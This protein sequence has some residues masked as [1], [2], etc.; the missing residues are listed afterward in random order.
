MRSERSYRQVKV[1]MI[2]EGSDEIMPNRAARQQG[3]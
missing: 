3:V 1:M 2:G